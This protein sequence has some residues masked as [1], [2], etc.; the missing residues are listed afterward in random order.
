MKNNIW[1]RILLISKNTKVL[2]DNILE[3][4]KYYLYIVNKN[5]ILR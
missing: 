5:E 1:I 2:F 3:N 4:Y